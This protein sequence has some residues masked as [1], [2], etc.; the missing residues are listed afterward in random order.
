MA[1]LFVIVEDGVVGDPILE[2]NFVECY[3][4][5]DIDNLPDGYFEF[6]RRNRPT[7]GP[8]QVETGQDYV[9]EDGKYVDRWLFREMT[10]DEKVAEQQRVK[11]QLEMAFTD[12]SSWTL[13]VDNCEWVPPTPHP[14]DGNRYR[15]DES[16]TSWVQV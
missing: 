5:I 12:I 15:W 16:T 6:E 7:P 10:A 8:Y 3:P 1:R 9:L 11:E 14:D 13:D 4:D 2:S